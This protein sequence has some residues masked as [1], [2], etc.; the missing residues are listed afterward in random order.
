MQHRVIRRHDLGL[1][2]LNSIRGSD[3]C[4]LAE[5]DCGQTASLEIIGDRE[6]NLSAL[7]IEQGVESVTDNPLF[8]AAQSNQT[9]RV[10]QVGFAV[11]FGNQGG[12][13]YRREEP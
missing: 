2:H 3:L 6:S 1:E 10:S 4:Q 13:G 11:C 7:V 5:Q 9:K 12:T 8:R